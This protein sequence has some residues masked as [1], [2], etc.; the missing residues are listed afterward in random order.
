MRT[1]GARQQFIQDR[2]EA[3]LGRRVAALS[4]CTALSL[5]ELGALACKVRPQYR[6][7]SLTWTATPPLDRSGPPNPDVVAVSFGGQA[8][9]SDQKS[10]R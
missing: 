4:C 1:V 6:F 7:S 8:P 10:S 3:R 2:T 5:F 9:T